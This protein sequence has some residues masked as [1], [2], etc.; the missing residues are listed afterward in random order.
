MCVVVFWL[1]CRVSIR[2]AVESAVDYDRNAIVHQFSPSVDTSA[3]IVAPALCAMRILL[4]RM[5]AELNNC[6]IQLKIARCVTTLCYGNSAAQSQALSCG[7]L[8][9]ALTAIRQHAN[10]GFAV[11]K[12]VELICSLVN[13]TDAAPILNSNGAAEVVALIRSTG[14]CRLLEVQAR[15]ETAYCRGD[16]CR[17]PE[18]GY[19]RAN[20]S[21]AGGYG[22]SSPRP[23]SL[24]ANLDLIEAAV[25]TVYVCGT[26]SHLI[27]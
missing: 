4:D 26:Q 3:G 23:G 1:Q 16:G 11:Q 19:P 7:A 17:Y 6:E 21:P 18:Q 20:G 9:Y 8:H 24:L 22:Y 12:L 10:E 15:R 25:C 13:C 5:C 14:W 27:N 2:C